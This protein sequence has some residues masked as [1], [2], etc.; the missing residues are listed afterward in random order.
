MTFNCLTRIAFARPFNCAGHFSAGGHLPSV[1][2]N[3][4]F[5]PAS[6]SAFVCENVDLGVY[7]V[8]SEEIKANQPKQ[9]T[10]EN[11]L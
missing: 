5:Q 10:C 7:G 8:R 4:P 9:P 6:I 2:A 3:F 1:A 11:A